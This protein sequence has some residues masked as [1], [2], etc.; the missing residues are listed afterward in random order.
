MKT[1]SLLSKLA[2]VAAILGIVLAGPVPV[3][4]Q[5]QSSQC[6]GYVSGESEDFE[7]EPGQCVIIQGIRKR[8]SKTGAPNFARL[9][10]SSR[11]VSTHPKNGTLSDGGIDMRGSRSCDGYVDVRVI[12]YRPNPGFIG[13]DVVEFFRGKEVITITVKPSNPKGKP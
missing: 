7:I 6:V 3:W 11:V 5:E 10:R 4:G 8:C 1:F 12:V 13:K 2:I 9:M